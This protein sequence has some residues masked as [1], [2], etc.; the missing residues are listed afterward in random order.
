MKIARVIPSNQKR[1]LLIDPDRFW[2]SGCS[3]QLGFRPFAFR[4][5]FYRLVRPMYLGV[6]TPIRRP[7]DTNT[8]ARSQRLADVEARDQRSRG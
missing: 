7:R 6:L 3:W 2:I 8:K 1:I 5:K 4:K